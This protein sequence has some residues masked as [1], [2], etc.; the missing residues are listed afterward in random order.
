MEQKKKDFL[1]GV[2]WKGSIQSHFLITKK[3]TKNALKIKNSHIH[4]KRNDAETK[5]L[6]CMH[7]QKHNLI[8]IS[9]TQHLH[10]VVLKARLK[11]DPMQQKWGKNTIK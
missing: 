5:R 3:G 7:A 9:I 10:T 1:Y 6:V 11:H 8:Y 2:R 4:K